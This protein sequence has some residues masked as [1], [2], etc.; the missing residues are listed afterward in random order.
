MA[1]LH[2]KE[3]AEDGEMMAV[4]KTMSTLEKG[5]REQL[6]ALLGTRS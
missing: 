2:R 4:Y 3:K 1:L 6:S 5:K